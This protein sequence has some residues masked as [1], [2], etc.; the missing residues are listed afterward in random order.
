MVPTSKKI[1]DKFACWCETT[2]QSKADSIDT[3]KA[4]IAT[5]TTEILTLKGGI[6]VLATE[7]KELEVA[8][9]K[10]NDAMDKLTA[11][12]QKENGDYQGEK[13]NMETTL[14]ALHRAIETLSGA[15]TGG[16]TG[17]LSVASEVRS[18]VLNSH[19]LTKLS[20]K[21]SKTFKQFLE[22][23]TVFIQSEPSDYYDQKAQAKASYSPQSATVTGILKDMYDEFAANLESAN[24]NESNLQKAYEDLMDEKKEQNSTSK[25]AATGKTGQKAEKS[26]KLAEAEQ[27]LEATQVELKEDEDFFAATRDQCKAKSDDWD[28][29]KRNRVE[30]LSGIHDALEILTSDDARSLFA[31]AHDARPQDTFGSAGVDVAFVQLAD[32]D[33]RERAYRAITKSGNSLRLASL[34][35]AVRTAAA[36]HFDSVIANMDST[37][38]VLKDEASEDVK[39]RDWCIDERDK[40][41]TNRED[42]QYA[43]DQLV[44][45]IARAESKKTGLQKDVERTTEDKNTLISQMEQALQDRTDENAAFLQAKDDDT[46][47]VALLE[48]AIA[49]LSTFSKNNLELLQRHHKKHR[50]QPAMEVSADQA[51]DATFSSA[52][53]RAQEGSAV[54]SMLTQIKEDLENEVKLGLAAE[55]KA[56]QDYAD[57]KAKSD[58]QVESYDAELANLATAIAETDAEILADTT[59]KTDTEGQH[60]ATVDY[61]ARIKG[62]CDWIEGAFTKRAEARK[63]ESD[64]IQ[65]AKAILSGAGGDSFGFLQ[66]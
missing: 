9:S 13:S 10:N 19:H 24:T 22:N 52:G 51:P 18:A 36:G 56:T 15:G 65:K 3:G 23:P 8:I 6:A 55:A 43:V 42:L 1:Y 57:L 61:L 2:T 16:D 58:A 46:N 32:S 29:R 44:A 14:G 11:I 39:Q 64:N 5:T 59:S 53:N 7:I 50:K 12:R 37:I 17:L 38:Q 60:T 54:V 40:E 62:N 27:K 21:D 45:K 41:N 25:A 31:D 26:Q 34:A 4:T 63:V 35:V 48:D 30:E 47:A 33:P 28:E 49:A 66:R 20:D